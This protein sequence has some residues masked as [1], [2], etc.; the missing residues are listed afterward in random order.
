MLC[1][2]VQTGLQE[3]GGAFEM[4]DISLA[5][6]IYHQALEEWKDDYHQYH[7]ECWVAMHDAQQ[8]LQALLEEFGETRSWFDTDEEKLLRQHPLE[9]Q[10]RLWLFKW[11]LQKATAKGFQP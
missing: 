4:R 1:I 11:R 9:M 8:S 6:S 7:E 3:L 10:R 5:E 2:A